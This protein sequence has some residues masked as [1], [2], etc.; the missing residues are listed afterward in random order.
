MCQEWLCG[1]FKPKG[2]KTHEG[3]LCNYTAFKVEV[4]VPYDISG[5]VN[6]F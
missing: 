3:L 5:A 6:N 2:K 1:Y 4:K